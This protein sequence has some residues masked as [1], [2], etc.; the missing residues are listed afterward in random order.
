MDDE[1]RAVEMTASQRLDAIATLLARG[2]Q[3]VLAT[4][5]EARVD[6]VSSSGAN[7]LGNVERSALP[8]PRGAALMSRTEKG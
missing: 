2:V 4:S 5:T 6:V 8:V 7:C 3:R 1:L